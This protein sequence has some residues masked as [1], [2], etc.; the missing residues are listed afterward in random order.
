MFWNPIG[1]SLARRA[2]RYQVLFN[3]VVR[4]YSLMGNSNGE[5]W[6][7]TLMDENP[8]VFDVGFY[9]GQST[10]EILKIRPSATVIGFDPSNFGRQSY[11]RSF[12]GDSRVRFVNAGFSDRKGKSTFY[13]YGNMCNSLGVR[14]ETNPGTATAYEVQIDTIDDF[15]KANNIESINFLKIDAEGFD[16]N[17]LEGASEMLAWQAVDIFTFEFASGW[18]GSKRYLWEV[19]AFFK[20][21]PYRLFRL[22]NGFL[23][24]FVYDHSVDSCTLL[25]AMY[26]GVSENRLAKGDVPIKDYGL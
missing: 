18:T 9:E 1:A 21:K 6:L 14:Q 19:E 7:L 23:C 20:D 26:V 3:V 25:S 8:L 12:V 15:V 13:D 17:V 4:N 22:F 2:I 16:L 11:E 10:A 24:P 5:K